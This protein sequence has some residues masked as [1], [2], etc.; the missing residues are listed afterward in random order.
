MLDEHIGA[1]PL[2]ARLWHKTV[3]EFLMSPQGL[4]LIT[5]SIGGAVM[6]SLAVGVAVALFAALV[7]LYAMISTVRQLD[8]MHRSAEEIWVKFPDAE[9]GDD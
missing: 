3:D 7:L 5:A 6:F 8:A 1:E 2:A 9:D 4:G